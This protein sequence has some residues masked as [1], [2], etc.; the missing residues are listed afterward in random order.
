MA[1]ALQVSIAMCMYAAH[2]NKDGRAKSTCI[3]L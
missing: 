2:D 3:G 1:K